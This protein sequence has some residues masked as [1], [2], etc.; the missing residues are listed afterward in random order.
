MPAAP[1]R[2]PPTPLLH[3]RPSGV[4]GLGAFAAV[5]LRAGTKLGRYTGRRFTAMQAAAMEWDST[6][7]YLFG[8]SDGTLIDG[9]R[10]GNA[11]RHLNHACEPNCEAHEEH[12]TRGR[13]H[14]V[15]HTLRDVRAGEELFLDYAL[16]VDD[17][18]GPGDYPCHCGSLRCRGTMVA[19]TD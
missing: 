5:D 17:A 10:G 15:I 1:L 18:E 8:L 13:L 12:G 2:T 19:V 16:T 11:M 9:G 3:V 6:L 7:T 4:H 14:L